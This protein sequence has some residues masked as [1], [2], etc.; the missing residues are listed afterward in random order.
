ML[1][2]P[3]AAAWLGAVRVALPIR[4]SSDANRDA[5]TKSQTK[6]SEKIHYSMKS[7]YQFARLALAIAGL[8]Q[9]AHAGAQLRIFDGTTTITIVDN[10]VN[11]GSLT[12]GRIVWDG[13]IGNFTLNTDVGTTFPVLGTLTNPVL[14]L[15]FNA[16]SNSAG[17]TLVLTFSADGFGPTNGTAVASLGGTAAGTVVYRTYGGTN[18]TLFSTSNL[19]TT[20]GPF[21]GAFSGTAAGGTV[22][23]AGPY[24]LSQQITIV[25]TGAGIT[26][27]DGL[28]TV[29]ESGTSVLLLGVG[30]LALAVITRM[31]PLLG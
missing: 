20:Q 22:N 7:L 2:S 21:T 16:V 12:T 1:R 17:G 11:D 15:S 8:T 13:T 24:A 26:T 28:L 29:P 25:H 4:G 23:N 27:G 14:D 10:G 3:L 18:N 5:D 9:L 31:R 19:L 30:I 6:T